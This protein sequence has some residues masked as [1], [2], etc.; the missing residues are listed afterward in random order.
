MAKNV[1]CHS[2]VMISFPRRVLNR[3]LFRDDRRPARDYFELKFFYR[4]HQCIPA[5]TSSLQNSAFRCFLR[6]HQYV[7]PCLQALSVS[8]CGP[9]NVC[10]PSLQHQIRFEKK[11]ILCLVFL[12]GTSLGPKFPTP[13]P[14]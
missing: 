6:K 10:F 7:C 4:P 14:H 9:F 13:H 12:Y 11:I 5:I 3:N 8:C 2:V 1:L